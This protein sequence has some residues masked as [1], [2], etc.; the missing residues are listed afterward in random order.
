MTRVTVLMGAPGAGKS[1]WL[2]NNRTDE[3]VLDTHAVRMVDQIDVGAYMDNFRAVGL[4]AIRNGQNVIIDATNTYPHHRRYWLQAARSCQS[5]ANLVA[6]DTA[7]QLLL[8]AQRSRRHPVP[9]RIV[10][11]HY[12]LMRRALNDVPREGWDTIQVVTRDR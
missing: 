9:Q 2:S 12:A 3:L 4:R 5:E 1:T 6:F 11:K 7:I 8:A 10:T